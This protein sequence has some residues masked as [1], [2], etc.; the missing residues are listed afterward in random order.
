MPAYTDYRG[1]KPPVSCELS[2]ELALKKASKCGIS[3]QNTEKLCSARHKKNDADTSFSRIC[4]ISFWRR[5]RDLNPRDPFE[6]YSLSR[7]AP[8][9]LGYFSS[10]V[11]AISGINVA[12]RVGFEPTVHSASPVFKTGSLNRSDTSPFGFSFIIIA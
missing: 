5:K 1:C 6:P 4:V 7:G 3:L 10:M 8:S 9:P 2:C 12:E 11:N